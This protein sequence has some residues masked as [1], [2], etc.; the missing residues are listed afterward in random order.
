MEHSLCPKL[1]LFG[2]CL[3]AKTVAFNEYDGI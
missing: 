2:M 1:H 3:Y